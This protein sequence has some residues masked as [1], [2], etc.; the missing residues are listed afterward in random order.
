[1]P[2]TIELTVSDPDYERLRSQAAA[3]NLSVPNLCRV[4]LG[5]EPARR[6]NPTGNKGKRIKQPK[7]KPKGETMYSESSQNIVNAVKARFRSSGDGTHCEFFTQA[8]ADAIEKAEGER[9]IKWDFLHNRLVVKD[10]TST[11]RF[12]TRV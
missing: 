5:L 9:P 2:R 11:G 7:R 12:S 10:D 4:R 6:G 1:M 8:E 3:H